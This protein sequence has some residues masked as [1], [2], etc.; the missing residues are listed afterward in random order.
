MTASEARSPET[1]SAPFESAAK[2]DAEDPHQSGPPKTA[3]IWDTIR[4]MFGVRR[5]TGSL[6]ENLEDELAREGSGDTAFSPEE[7][8]LLGNILRLRELR[9]DDVMIPRADIDAV[10]SSS[11]LSRVMELFEE[12]SHSRMPVYEET[13]DDPRGM[14]HIKD[15]MA[16]IA[17]RASVSDDKPDTSGEDDEET[18]QR[19]HNLRELDLSRVD[20]S[21]SL[22]EAGLVRELLFVPP[23]MPATDLMAKMQADRIQ[24][25]LVIDEYGGTDGL[26]SLEDLVEEVVGDIEDEHDEDEEAMLAETGDGGWI[27][28]PRLPLEELDQTLG[29]QFA[30][31]EISEDV[32]T[33]GGLLFVSIGRVP[34]RGELLAAPGLPGYEFEVLDADPRRIKRL[35]IRRRKLDGRLPEQRRR[36]KKPDAQANSGQTPAED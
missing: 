18:P 32:D 28:D 35:R 4:R 31:G 8:M 15:L 16:F 11:S 3:A 17:A 19:G 2:Q 14:I 30:T 6:R 34:V 36:I 23:S 5:A 13:L 20:L 27:A 33:L 24:M 29:T 1:S 26:V 21:G 12:S 10:E 25:A 9:V 22:K 7:R